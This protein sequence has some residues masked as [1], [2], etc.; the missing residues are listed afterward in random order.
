MREACTRAVNR[1]MQASH[2]R[3]ATPTELRDI[4]ARIMRAK[5]NLARENPAAHRALS[6]DE[7][8]AAAGKRAAQEIAHER[9]QK[10][11]RAELSILAHDR[12]TNYRASQVAGR[13]GQPAADANE[14]DALERALVHKYDERNNAFPSV[15]ETANATT[16]ASLA[17][18]TDV[19]ETVNPNLWQR[20]QRG[21]LRIEPVRRA[22]TDALHGVTEGIPPEFVQAAKVYHDIVEA[23]RQEF[24]AAGGAVGRLEDFGAP[25][26]WSARLLL[27]YK[28]YGADMRQVAALRLTGKLKEA[29][30]LARTMENRARD[31]FVKNMVGWANRDRYVHANG[32]RYS[33]EELQGFFQEAWATIVSNGHTKE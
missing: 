24:N 11:K 9:A 22:F 16:D 7:Q 17:A 13:P 1:A 15:D 28:G 6:P 33:E 8:M 25:H 23:L 12:L 14:L 4:E 32:R 19:F 27:R 20:I 26:T 29:D 30:A 18:I 2:G 21:I 3:D 5:Q 10:V 31:E